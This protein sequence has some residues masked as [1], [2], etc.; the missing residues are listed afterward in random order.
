[1][2]YQRKKNGASERIRNRR[3]SRWQR[4]AL[5]TELHSHTVEKM[6]RCERIRTVDNH[7]GN[8]MLY[9]LSYTRLSKEV[10]NIQILQFF[11]KSSF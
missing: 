9:Q 5:P 2:I 1:M 10:F 6:E 11:F 3:Q 7:V 4:D 8:V